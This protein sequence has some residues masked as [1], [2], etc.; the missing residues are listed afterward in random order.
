MVGKYERPALPI[1]HG[2]IMCNG[3]VLL[4]S[5]IDVHVLDLVKREW[6]KVDIAFVDGK[7]YDGSISFPKFSRTNGR[8]IYGYD[9]ENS[10]RILVFSPGKH[11]ITVSFL[12]FSIKNSRFETALLTLLSSTEDLNT[13]MVTMVVDSNLFV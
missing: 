13:N 10:G 1:C 8:V 3:L 11:I 2:V 12:P 6:V 4:F 5:P 9:K 7:R